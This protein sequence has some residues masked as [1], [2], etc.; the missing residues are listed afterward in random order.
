MDRN[1]KLDVLWDLLT[2][3]LR[4]RLKDGTATA[5]DRNTARQLLKD[6][7]V[8]AESP[9]AGMPE[10]EKIDEQMGDIIRYPRAIGE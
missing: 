7:D 10:F 9:D 4:K 3:D 6:N 5:T 1:E 2:E 8:G